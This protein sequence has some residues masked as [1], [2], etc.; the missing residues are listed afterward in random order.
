MVGGEKMNVVFVKWF[1][2]INFINIYGF[3][4]GI[5]WIFMKC[6]ELNYLNIG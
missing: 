3:I 6:I 1:D 5:V 4:E 2:N